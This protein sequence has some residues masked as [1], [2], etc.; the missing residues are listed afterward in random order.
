MQTTA[1]IL[2]GCCGCVN[3]IIQV[4]IVL[5][6]LIAIPLAL[7]YQNRMD[8]FWGFVILHIVMIVIALLVSFV[9]CNSDERGH[10]HETQNGTL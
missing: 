2:A 10:Y 7:Y 8:L 6:W 4:A 9:Q 3:V 5:A 1:Q